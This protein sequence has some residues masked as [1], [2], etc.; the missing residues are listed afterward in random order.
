M[1]ARHSGTAT[2]TAAHLD[3]RIND[4][5]EVH[6]EKAIKWFHILA[7][8]K[9]RRESKRKE[10]EAAERTKKFGHDYESIVVPRLR[11]ERK[12]KRPQ[13]DGEMFLYQCSQC[14]DGHTMTMSTNL[15]AATKR[16]GCVSV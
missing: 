9:G 7:R 14:A 11:W 6:P 8:A 12:D 15:S 5:K 1:P 4:R 2:S 13:A 16:K 10:V 3:L